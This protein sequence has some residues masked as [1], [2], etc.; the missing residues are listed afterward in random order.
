MPGGVVVNA[1]RFGRVR[2]VDCELYLPGT[3]AKLYREGR[4]AVADRVGDQL[5]DREHDRVDE[6]G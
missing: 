5:A 3:P 4:P 6:P 2:V 1:R